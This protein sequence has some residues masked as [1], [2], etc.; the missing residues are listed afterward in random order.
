[1][2]EESGICEHFYQV[3]NSWLELNSLRSRS[4]VGVCSKYRVL[5]KIQLERKPIHKSKWEIPG[6]V[7]Q[8]FTCL[9]EW[10]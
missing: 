9:R 5:H 1:M 10:I 8:E 7:Y 3:V 4:W 2:T 6:T